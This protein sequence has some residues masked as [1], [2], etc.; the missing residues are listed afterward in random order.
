MKPA[1]KTAIISTRV[2]AP[3]KRKAKAVFEKMGLT[4]SQAI[5]LFLT[6]AVEENAIPFSVNVPNAATRAALKADKEN[7]GLRRHK[8]ADSLYTSLGI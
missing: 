8:D 2:R 4:T 6:K 5:T 1:T 7:R 3:L